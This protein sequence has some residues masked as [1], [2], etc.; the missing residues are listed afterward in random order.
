MSVGTSWKENASH[1]QIYLHATCLELPKKNLNDN[2]RCRLG[3]NNA[4]CPFC[5]ITQRNQNNPY[6]YYYFIYLNTEII[7]FIF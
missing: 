5:I 4:D 1:F 6:F 3:V 2:L 7:L